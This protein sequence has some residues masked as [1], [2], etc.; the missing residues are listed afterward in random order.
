MEAIRDNDRLFPSESE[1]TRTIRSPA[2]TQCSTAE[3]NVDRLGECRPVHVGL[4]HIIY[5]HVVIRVSVLVKNLYE[6]F[7]D[8]GNSY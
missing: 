2:W 1:R 7:V 3:R 5:I 6:L 4:I 8:R